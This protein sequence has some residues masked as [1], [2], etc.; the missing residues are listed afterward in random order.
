ML[1][2]KHVTAEFERSADFGL[3]GSGTGGPRLIPQAVQPRPSHRLR[4]LM[5]SAS[6]SSLLQKQNRT[7]LRP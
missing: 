7:K 3:P 1:I 5:P 6:V 2:T 4:R